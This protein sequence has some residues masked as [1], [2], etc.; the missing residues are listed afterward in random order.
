MKK[1]TMGAMSAA[2]LAA[3]VVPTAASANT[4]VTPQ[5][6]THTLAIM[7]TTDIHAHLMPYDYMTDEP[8]NTY[9]LSKVMSVVEEQREKFAN[10]LL[11]DNGDIVQGSILGNMETI[12][13]DLPEG[14]VNTIIQAMNYMDYDAA[15]LGNHEFNFGLPIL[16]QMIETSDFPWL[17]ANVF[18][19]D[20]DE[21]AYEPYVL[22]DREVD[23]EQITVGVTGFVPPQ[24][25]IWDKIHLDGN[26]Y[27]DP[28]VETAER[29]IPE[30]KEQGADIIIVAAHSGLSESDT[31]GE[32]AALELTKVEGIDALITG[33]L[34]YDFP[35]DTARFADYEGVDLEKGTINGVP[36]VMP[37]SWGR[38]L[39]MIELELTHDNGEWEVVDGM[40]YNIS[41]ADYEPHQG[42]VDIAQD[43]HERTIEYVNGPVGETAREMNTY[44]ARVMDNAV[45]QLVN[46]AQIDFANTFVSGTE[47]ESMP[48]LSAAAPFQA[49]RFGPDYYTNVQDTLAIRD[50]ADIYIYDNTLHIVKVN[51][52][53]VRRWLEYSA[54]QFNQIDPTETDAQNLTNLDFRGFNFDVIE[55]IEYEIDVTKPV[56]ERI[57]TLNYNG[58]AVDTDDEFLV[59]TNNYRA[60]GGGDHLLGAESVE[61]VYEGTEENREVIIEYIRNEGTVDVLPSNNWQIKPF[62]AA[63]PVTFQSSPDAEAYI[64]RAGKEDFITY[65]S[66]DAQGFGVY[67]YNTLASH[68]DSE[69]APGPGVPNPFSD[70]EETTSGFS[71]MMWAYQAGIING[72]EDGTFRPNASVSRA[73]VAT[74]LTRALEL[75]FDGDKQFRDVV[76]GSFFED[77]I[78]ATVAAGVFNGI[79]DT[80]FAP[81]NPILRGQ[82]AATLVRGFD[83]EGTSETPFTDIDGSFY[84]DYVETLYAAGVISGVSAAEFGTYQELTR[85]DFVVLLDRLMN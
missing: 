82:V 2:L 72:H 78:Q 9:G 74:M 50:V 55:G 12:L 45:V 54:R 20:T 76:P 32:N 41:T 3:T 60:S 80:E 43:L 57:V 36:T 4:E 23:G 33:H 30:M 37:S 59:V 61:A 26:I 49:A 42:I 51:G 40:G 25:M 63:G 44:F 69:P 84:Q 81:R 64:A 5:D 35:G 47:Y 7:G 18:D 56:N 11:I 53:D 17:G 66:E 24:I 68:F 1:L 16:D 79:S 62:E 8:N 71:S 28:I 52:A 22:L 38:L 58:E 19:A 14:E 48:I 27:V 85:R 70:L 73:E 34:H 13:N 46:E 77:Y 83:L 6:D 39:G 15:A 31:S 10:T 75:P 21:H 67:E 29:I 65:L